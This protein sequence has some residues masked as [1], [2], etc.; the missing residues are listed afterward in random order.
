ME[1]GNGSC[2]VIPQARYGILL[3]SELDIFEKRKKNRRLVLVLDLLLLT[4]RRTKLSV[5]NH[6]VFAMFEFL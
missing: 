6:P 1:Y 5:V 4:R 2:Q 3:G